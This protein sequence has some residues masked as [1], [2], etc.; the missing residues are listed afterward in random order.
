[1]TEISR[2][3]DVLS[4]KNVQ[5]EEILKQETLKV[6]KEAIE[7]LVQ[8]R[9]VE[10]TKIAEDLEQRIKYIQEK[11]EKISSISTGLIDEYVV[12]LEERINEILKNQEVDK[13]R[14]AQEVVIYAD[15][16]S[17]EEQVCCKSQQIGY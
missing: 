14:L 17:I 4:I 13:S 10:G 16:C 11:V 6:V 15:K 8:M 3:P 5:D 9:E 1:M 2:F 12:K 7:N